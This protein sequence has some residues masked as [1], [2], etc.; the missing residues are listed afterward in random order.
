MRKSNLIALAALLAIALAGVVIYRTQFGGRSDETTKLPE[1][2]GIAV[3]EATAQLLHNQGNVVLILPKRGA[4]QDPLTELQRS[5]FAKTIAKTKGLSLAATESMATERPGTMGA[6]GLD[7]AEF[8]QLLQRHAGV[9]TFVSLAGLPEF[10]TDALPTLKGKQFIVVGTP[11]PQLK[12][13]LLDGTVQILIAP[14]TIPPAEG[15]RPRTPDEWF[16]FAYQTFTPATAGN[17][18]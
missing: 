11:T 6:G 7:P 2:L 1:G 15:K 12:A 4:F 14:R 3:A 18:P 5:A 13:L 8:Q 10:P 17:L 16:H 9:N